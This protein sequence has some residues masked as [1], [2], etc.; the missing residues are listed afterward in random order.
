M[1]AVRLPVAVGVKV[2]AT[3]QLEPAARLVTVWQ[4]VPLEGVALAKSAAFVPPRT[5]PEMASVALPVFVKVTTC[6]PLVWPVSKLPNAIVVP[7][8]PATG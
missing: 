6:C 2:A 4:S 7:L 1:V 8:K 3:L 5:M